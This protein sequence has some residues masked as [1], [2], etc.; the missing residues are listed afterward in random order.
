MEKTVIDA[1]RRTVIGK[2]VGAL[3]RAGKLPGIMYG[4]NFEPT[5]IEMDLHTATLTLAG[6]SQSHI[7]TINLEGAEHAALV[8]EKQRDYIRGTLKHIDFQ[9]VSLTEKIR[10][11]ISIELVGTSPAIKNFNGVVITELS[12]VEVEAFPQDLP[13]KFVVDTSKLLNLGD[14]V[15]VKDLGIPDKVEV[16]QDP[17][18]IIVLITSGAEEVTETEGEEGASEPE[19]IERGKKEEDIED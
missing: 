7:V 6:L 14:S 12:E 2:Q 17:D 3:R 16:L 1:N 13:E 4:H 19:V 9:V 11:Y 5:P 10:T 15:A 18:E 8:R